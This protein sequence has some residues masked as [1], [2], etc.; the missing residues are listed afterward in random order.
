M[1]DFADGSSV[2]GVRH[3][4][5]RPG[6]IKPGVTHRGHR[7]TNPHGPRGSFRERHVTLIARAHRLSHH[8]RGQGR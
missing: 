4:G 3:G 8:Q 2:K 6:E 1:G 5:N 7:L